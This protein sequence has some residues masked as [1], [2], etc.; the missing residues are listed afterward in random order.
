MIKR[1]PPST[2]EGDSPPFWQIMYC[3][4]WSAG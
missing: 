3:R 2:S 1:T 4:V